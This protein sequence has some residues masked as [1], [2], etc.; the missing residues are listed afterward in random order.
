MADIGV[1]PLHH[2]QYAARAPCRGE[3]RILLLRR[4]FALKL[5]ERPHSSASHQT[6]GSLRCRHLNVTLTR[7]ALLR[8]LDEAVAVEGLLRA[9][10][11][12]GEDEEEEED[13]EGEELEGETTM[14]DPPRMN[15][16]RRLGSLQQD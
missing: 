11:E 10:A 7:I 12:E 3:Y 4:R 9:A 1:L 16:T 14:T 8:H 15:P 5:R 13:A 2:I 6:L